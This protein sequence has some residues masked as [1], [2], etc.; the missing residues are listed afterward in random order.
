MDIVERLR[1]FESCGIGDAGQAADEIERLRKE[2]DELLA[3]SENLISAMDRGD[4]LLPIPAV[5][6]AIASIKGA[7]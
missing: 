3:A 2:R 5:R 4:F 7:E 6:I 1:Q